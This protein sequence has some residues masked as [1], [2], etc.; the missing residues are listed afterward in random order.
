MFRLRFAPRGMTAVL[1]MARAADA[2]RATSN[3][4]PT[5]EP[6][7][8]AVGPAQVEVPGQLEVLQEELG[9]LEFGGGD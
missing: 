8:G 1:L 2:R 6:S 4:V 5:K 9:I 3:K 7:V